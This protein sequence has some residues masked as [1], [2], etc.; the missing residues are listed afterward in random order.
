MLCIRGCLQNRNFFV[1]FFFHR[2]ASD[3]HFSPI[4]S[5][6]IIYQCC[7]K[8]ISTG[9]VDCI[10]IVGTLVQLKSCWRKVF[11]QF[12]IS[13]SCNLLIVG[14]TSGLVPPLAI[15]FDTGPFIIATRCFFTYVWGC[16]NVGIQV[17]NFWLKSAY[18]GTF[19]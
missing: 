6:N 12:E 18:V 9:L 2:L 10:R 15:A 19:W 5:F 4:E 13:Y 8:C 14:I 3:G 16:L 1:N 11:G 17:E 7:W